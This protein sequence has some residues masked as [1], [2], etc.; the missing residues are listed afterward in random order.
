ME[1]KK[2]VFVGALVLAFVLGLCLANPLLKM[3]SLVEAKAIEI[4]L[5]PDIVYAPG[6]YDSL[7]P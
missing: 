6:I 1:I 2:K 7:E 3:S 5:D 4:L